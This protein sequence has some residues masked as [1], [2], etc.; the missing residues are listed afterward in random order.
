MAELVI[1]LTPPESWRRTMPPTP[2]RH[3][4]RS[5]GGRMT[6]AR[7][8]LRHHERP[9]LAATAGPIIRIAPPPD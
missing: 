8:S 5:S 9:G 1:R 4:S 3:C 6:E 7:R 2:N